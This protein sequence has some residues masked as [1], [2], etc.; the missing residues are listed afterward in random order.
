MNV[1]KACWMM[2]LVLTDSIGF[3]MLSN[4]AIPSN[5]FIWEQSLERRSEDRTEAEK[6]RKKKAVSGKCASIRPQCCQ[7]THWLS[8][9][10]CKTSSCGCVSIVNDSPGNILLFSA[11]NDWVSGSESVDRALHYLEKYF[12][13]ISTQ[14]GQRDKRARVCFHGTVESSNAF[15]WPEDD[16]RVNKLKASKM[17]QIKMK[18]VNCLFTELSFLQ[19]HKR[20]GSR[21]CTP[22]K[23]PLLSSRLPSNITNRVDPWLSEKGKKSKTWKLNS[24]CELRSILFCTTVGNPL[25]DT[26]FVFHQYL[27]LREKHVFCFEAEYDPKIWKK[28]QEF[29][30]GGQ[31]EISQDPSTKSQT[32]CSLSLRSLLTIKLHLRNASDWFT[33]IRLVLTSCFT[34]PQASS[35]QEAS[36][37]SP[38]AVYLYDSEEDRVTTG[39]RRQGQM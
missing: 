23:C 5:Q 13:R 2:D 37:S 34:Y 6:R 22:S 3:L 8:Q 18:G 36:D 15:S 35:S 1:S 12:K 38:S 14:T 10:S 29:F 39:S 19:Y 28:L 4:T 30:R 24:H 21:L 20:E 27:Y 33:G 11:V 25:S 31:G 32:N 7:V 9:Q 26:S 16:S 17:S